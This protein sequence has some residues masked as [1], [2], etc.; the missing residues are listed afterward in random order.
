MSRR[1]VDSLLFAILS[2][3]L[4]ALVGQASMAAPQDSDKKEEK[5]P[6]PFK[7]R[8]LTQEMGLYSI[9]PVSPDK[10]S[11]LLLAQ[12]PDSAPN[13]YVMSLV[14]RSIRPPLTNL[15]WG[16][17][18]PQWSP[19]SQSIAFAGF[20]E[21]ASFPDIYVADVK[22]GKSRQLTKNNFV[23]KEPVFTPDG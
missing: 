2:T 17:T 3:I 15:K 16:V 11:V 4:A 9:G 1:L 6:E 18:D 13:L 14:D 8:R 22:T 21:T 19:D 20:G 10:Q 12:R 7:I 5:K 23:D